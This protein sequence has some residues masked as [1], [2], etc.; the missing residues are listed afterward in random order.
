MC[1]QPRFS[2]LAG[3]GGCDHCGAVAVAHVVLQNEYRT[4]TT[5]LRPDDWPQVSIVNAASQICVNSFGWLASFG[6]LG[7]DPNAHR[8]QR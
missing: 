7:L 8:P 3:D 2:H 4:D 5:L 1:R 6:A